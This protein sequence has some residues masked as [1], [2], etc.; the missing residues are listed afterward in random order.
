MIR[1]MIVVVLWSAAWL[2]WAGTI[3]SEDARQI[4]D[5]L[6]S[7]SRHSR[8]PSDLLDPQLSADEKSKSLKHFSASHYDLRL[9]PTTAISEVDGE[10]ARVP[11]R[12]QFDDGNG[13]TADLTAVATFVKREGIWYF[14]N[15]DFMEWPIS[16]IAVSVVLCLIGIGYSVTVIV[17]TRRLAARKSPRSRSLRVFIPFFWP[18]LFRG[19]R[20]E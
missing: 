18:Q 20:S 2:M 14:S 12:V 10:R 6:D 4:L 13:N 3:A 11:V 5:L 16:L 17:L 7:M 8:S 19:C 9:I 1:R 15:Y